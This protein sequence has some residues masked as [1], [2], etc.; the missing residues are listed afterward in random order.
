MSKVM[1]SPERLFDRTWRPGHPFRPHSNYLRR[2]FLYFLFGTLLLVIVSYVILTDSTRVRRM[3]EDD[4]GKLLGGRVVVER[5]HLSI[6]QGLRL[7]GVKLFVG[8]RKQNSTLLFSSD[9]FLIEYNPLALLQRRIEATRIVAVG[10]EVHLTED[11]KTGWRNYAALLEARQANPLPAAEP[12]QRIVLPEIVLRDARVKYTRLENGQTV[13]TSAIAIE[14]LL[15]QRAESDSYSFAFQSR[16]KTTAIGPMVEGT[17]WS[18]GRISANLQNFDFGPD[19]K[20][21]LPWPVRQWSEEQQLNGR[22]NIPT[23]TYSPPLTPGGKPGYFVTIKLDGVKLSVDPRRWMGDDETRTVEGVSRAL[24]TLRHAGL[25]QRGFVKELSDLVLPGKIGLTDVVGTF[26]FPGDDTIKIEDVTG[27]LEDIHFT[28]SGMINGFSPDA[29]ARIHIAS[30]TFKY[31]EIPAVPKYLNSL[32]P[33]VR[34]IYDRFKPRG[35]CGFALDLVRDTPG[36]RPHV[37]GKIDIIDGNFTFDKFPYPMRKTT[38]RMVLTHNPQTNR[39]SLVLDRIQGRGVAGGPNENSI[40]TIEGTIRSFGPEAEVDVSVSGQGITSEP[41]LIAAFPPVTSKALKV[42]DAPGKG[43]FPKFGGDFVCLIKRNFGLD[44]K[45]IIQTNIRLENASGALEGFPYPLT[46]VNGDLRIFDDHVELIDVN[47]KKADATLRIDGKI[48]WPGEDDPIPTDGPLLRPNLTVTARNVP[49]DRELLSALPEAQ[50]L[51][52]E[53]LGAGGRFDINGT[54]KPA[55]AGAAD[56][57][58]LNFDLNLALRDG[59]LWP[60]DGTFAVSDVQ[61]NLRLKNHRLILSELRGR[62]GDAQLMARGEVNWPNNKPSVVLQA[63]AR[64]LALDSPLYKLLP[65]PAQAAWDQVRPEGTVDVSLTYSGAVTD[66][67]TS[68]P[69]SPNLAGGYEL[70]LTPRKLSVTPTAVPYRLDELTGSVRILPER[71]ELKSLTGRHGDAK[72]RFSGTGTTGR[73]QVWDFA[74]AAESLSVDDD[75]RNAVPKP[76]GDLFK[77]LG[78]GGKIGFE[79][80]KLRVAAS[81]PAS[82]TPEVDFAVRLKSEGASLDVGVPLEQVKGG[83]DLVGSSRGGKLSS[84]TGKMAIDSLTLAG[85]SVTGFSADMHKPAEQE[86]LTIR[87]MKATLARG[88]MAGQIDYAFSDTGPSRYAVNLNLRDAD[89]TELAGETDH[90]I[91]G[92]LSASLALEGI[93]D[94]PDSRRGRG[95][96]SVVGENMYRIPL[97]LG[98]LQITNL[99]LPITSPFKEASARYSMDGRRVTFEQIELRSNNMLMQGDGAMDFGTRQ[100]RMSFVTDS[101]TWP[102]LP[103]IEDILQGARH[104]LLQIRVRGRLDEPKVSARSMNTLSTTVDE[105]LRGDEKP[106][107]AAKK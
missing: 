61:G 47:M 74:L 63:E 105:V 24:E 107:T 45:F 57:D 60:I 9:S 7:D 97:V 16:G 36:G 44:T 83:I 35:T 66:P 18:D 25:D 17:M 81:E 58:E 37:T 103:I 88:S 52:L 65:A 12:N 75:F 53:K 79:F 31:I 90:D 106:T 15:R 4:L 70:L 73:S 11:T 102:K 20:A 51:W 85:R 86:Q 39:D 93:A 50:R 94:K 71:V 2:A 29:V 59:T 8:D 69:A 89:V 30:P 49:I 64:D 19:V 72:L 80:T 54:I 1:P 56:K 100:V 6:F 76:L 104:E 41:A 13:E 14:G 5:A 42:F 3:A 34:E 82:A 91:R 98:L 77:S 84:L 55:E 96:V 46:G 99:S 10:P 23:L 78:L 28:L 87:N 48:W 92:A 67:A 33:A 40:V 22:L 95:D 38:G 68:Q 43:E 32:P 62:R 26:T 27:R 21:M 101:T